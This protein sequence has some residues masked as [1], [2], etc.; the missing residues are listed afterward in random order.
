M[1]TPWALGIT[2]VRQSG[3]LDLVRDLQTTVISK[4]AYRLLNMILILVFLFKKISDISF[5]C[6]VNLLWYAPAIQLPL[7]S[8]PSPPSIHLL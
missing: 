7:K 2:T 6:V 1:R 8:I 4:M 5:K 3:G